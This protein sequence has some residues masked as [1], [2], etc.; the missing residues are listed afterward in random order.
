MITMEEKKYTVYMHTNKI[1]NKSYVGITSQP[2]EKRWGNNG[3]K[4]KRN[5]YFWSAIQK[6]GW[7][8]FKHIIFMTNLT[9]EEACHIEQL[10]I[11]LYYTNN[12]EYG[13]NL[14]SGGENGFYGCHYSDEQ[15]QKKSEQMKG[16]Y[17]GKNNPMYGVSPKERMDEGT[18]NNWKESVQ[19]RMSSEEFKEKMRQ[20]NIG[21]KYSD[22]INAK[23]GL[24]GTLNHSARP[25]CQFSKDGELIRQWEYATLASDAL[26]IDLSSIIAC[27]RGT[28]GRKSAGGYLWKYAYDEGVAV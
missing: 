23:K 26:N 1:N 17:A 8:N 2:V 11:A 22:E 9:Q 7:D 16:L 27:C 20:I 25:V 10:L 24:K 3:Y 12:S 6:Y 18:Y 4:Y 28:N 5:E 13:Y 15:K 14:S 19:K 21:K